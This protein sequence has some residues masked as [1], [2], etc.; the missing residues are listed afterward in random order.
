MG[1]PCSAEL[2]IEAGSGLGAAIEESVAATNVCGETVKLAH[3]VSEMND[4]LFAWTV[5]ILVGGA[6]AHEGAE[7]AV[8][9]VEERHVLMEGEL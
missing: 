8:L 4:V 7:D 6:T 5:A 2:V 9:H 1:E 3:T